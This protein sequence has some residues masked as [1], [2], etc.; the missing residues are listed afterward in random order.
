MKLLKYLLTALMIL[1][2]GFAFSQQAVLTP[3]QGEK[4]LIT[5]VK[6]GSLDAVRKAAET[7]GT[8]LSVT[9][10]DGNTALH[11][12]A[13]AGNNDVVN[14]LMSR[15]LSTKTKNSAGLTAYETAEKAGHHKTFIL[16]RNED[17]KFMTPAV[18][19]DLVMKSLVIIVAGMSI[20]FSFLTILVLTVMLNSRIMHALGW[21]KD[22]PEETPAFA[23]SGG[24]SKKV[25]AI[26]AAVKMFQKENQ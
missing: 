26:S 25:A 9:D 6:S 23:A 5:A 11:I 13:M 19:F 4:P 24:N 20:V 18:V 17:L 8:V 14:Y 22:E 10:A 1:S 16:I 7:P 12:A 15:G 2:Y 3:P 21:D